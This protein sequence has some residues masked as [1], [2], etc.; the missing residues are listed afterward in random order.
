M[1]EFQINNTYGLAGRAFRSLHP[2]LQCPHLMDWHQIFHSTYQISC[3]WVLPARH[4]LIKTQTMMV[5]DKQATPTLTCKHGIQDI[6]QYSPLQHAYHLVKF[7]LMVFEIHMC[8]IYNAPY[9]LSSRG[10]G[11]QIHS[12]VVNLPTT[13]CDDRAKGVG[14]MA[15]HF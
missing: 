6:S 9:R 13:F 4:K 12:P 7:H 1:K 11:R 8:S 5:N 15:N 2:M 3:L 10:F 14:V